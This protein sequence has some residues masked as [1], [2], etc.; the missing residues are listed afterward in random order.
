MIT[1]ITEKTKGEGLV[2]TLFLDKPIS[3]TMG[4]ECHLIK[5]D[6][7]F[8]PPSEEE[9]EAGYVTMAFGYFPSFKVDTSNLRYTQKA[10]D[11]KE[12]RKNHFNLLRELKECY[13][14]GEKFRIR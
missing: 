14:T 1:E 11:A 2:T 4:W 3:T 5:V 8:C 9:K 6:T 10:K 13:F 12:A 7:L